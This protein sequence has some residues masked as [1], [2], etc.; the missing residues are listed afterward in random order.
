MTSMTKNEKPILTG[1]GEISTLIHC[2]CKYKP[3][4]LWKSLAVPQEVKH[5]IT[6][7]Q[8]FNS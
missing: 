7:R 2:W 4:H 8:E 5:K 3:L 1:Y 6:M